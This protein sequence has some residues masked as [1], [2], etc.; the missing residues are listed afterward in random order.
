MEQEKQEPRNVK[1]SRNRNSSQLMVNK[2]Q[3]H[4]SYNCKEVNSANHLGD[5]MEPPGENADLPIP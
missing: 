5:E 3:E 2:T 1:V 4:Q